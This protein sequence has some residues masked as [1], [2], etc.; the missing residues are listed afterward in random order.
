MFFFHF[1][2]ILENKLEL[3]SFDTEIAFPA[4]AA[5]FTVIV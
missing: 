2:Y 5:T 3:H 1:L 4:G